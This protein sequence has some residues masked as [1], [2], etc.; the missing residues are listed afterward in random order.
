[1]GGCEAEDVEVDGNGIKKWDMSRRWGKQR[2][3]TAD[4]KRERG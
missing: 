4:E 2:E 1:L 3:M